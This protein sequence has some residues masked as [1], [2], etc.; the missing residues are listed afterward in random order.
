MTPDG[1]GWDAPCAISELFLY[2]GAVKQAGTQHSLRLI[3]IL[4]ILSA[5]APFT[6]DT[7]LPG[8]H[9]MAKDFGVG[10]GLIELTLS[11]F[12]LGLAVGQLFYG[13]VI[14]AIGRRR[15]L[16][17]GVILYILATTVCLFTHNIHLLIAMR[18]LQALGGCS[19]ML[20][21][22]AILND[23]FDALENARAQSLLMVVM[24]LGP[25]LAPILGGFLIA[26]FGWRSVFVFMLAFGVVCALLVALF[27][28]ETLAAEDRQPLHL[29]GILRTWTT[30][31]RKPQFTIPTLVGACAQACMFAFITGSSFVFI[32]LH[33][34]S[35]QQYGL[36]FA[37]IALA[38]IVGAQLNRVALRIW[39]PAKLLSFAQILN[40]A[41]G[42][43]LVAAVPTSSLIALLVPLWLCVLS[44]G[45]SGADSVALAMSGC[46]ENSGSGSSLIGLLQFAG[47]FAVSS[48]IAS[49]QNGTALPMT[50]S[51]AACASVAVLLWFLTPSRFR[52]TQ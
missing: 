25:I 6:T 20:I 35:T 14:D 31:L 52:T 42:A 30:L 40:L 2:A 44:L 10:I 41:A 4:G 43:L 7:Y 13:P 22:R 3:I 23:L 33:G 49:A 1:T 19:G 48:L 34:V 32:N 51:I 15:P 38:L 46:R 5:F 27:I 28:P 50:I 12:F 29:T 24:M 16:F 39:S 47:A 45:F 36:L 18:F 11:L 21:G 9:A 17:V 37:L 8:F 26:H